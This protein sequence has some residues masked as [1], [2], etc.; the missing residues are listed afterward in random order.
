M[1][2]NKYLKY[3]GAGLLTMSLFSAC[4]D[5]YESE[6]VEQFDIDYLFSRSDSAGVQARKFLNEIYANNLYNG[7]NRVG[8]DYLD[9]ATDDATSISNEEPDVLKLYMGQFTAS[10]R[11]T[12]DMYWGEFYNGIRKTNILINHIDVV[13][14]NLK[15][16]TATGKVNP[17]NVSMKAEARFLRAHFYFELVKRYGG[18]PLLG[19]E[20]YDLNDN[21]EL[22]RNTFEEC[23]KYIVDE[24]DAIQDDLRG[25]PMPDAG[26]FAH[27][28]TKE[29]CMAMKSRVLL[30]AASPLFNESP[31]VPGNEL[32]GYANY[33]PSRWNLAA[34]AA[35]DFI[36]QFGPNGKGNIN[37]TADVRDVFLSFY[38]QATNPELIF[39]RQDGKNKNI[40]TNN[41]PLG[42]TGNALG[43]G[44]TTP[45]QNLVDA[46]PM[47]DGKMPGE[48]SKYV[49]NIN[50]PY[51]NRDPRL[52]KTILHNG[53]SWLGRTLD[54]TQ[55][56]L[57]NPSGA[58]SNQTG[59]YM[60][61]F[62]GKYDSNGRTDY[63]DQQIHFWTMFRYAEI[64]LNYAEALNE[65]EAAPSDEVY[66]AIIALRQRAG[67]E[68]GDDGL[69]GLD[70]N[71]TQD[72]MREVIQNERRIEL[73][74]E[75]HRYW[76]IRRWKIAEDVLNQPLRGMS[77]SSNSG[78]V[79]YNEVDVLLPK[80]EARR[81]LYP[82]PYSEVIK[83]RNMIQNPN[84]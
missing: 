74:F 47:L 75:E 28:P 51:A 58:S 36:D 63:D 2:R 45:S 80:F 18:V 76:D 68:A 10:N 48:S 59:Y 11:V 26:E 73:A 21:M 61:K 43:N 82:I 84:W 3:L 15:Y 31:L 27:T 57:N 23:I 71:M 19:D 41:G 12:S 67:I 5:G 56:G 13:P 77:I 32:V 53:S 79:T 22:P 39:F 35:K 72:Q 52:N 24:L 55:G 44:R 1:I 8:G 60:C 16:T 30:Y 38:D 54:M 50:D 81:Y 78:R 62:M 29:A 9:A 20:V 66:N 17:L 7:H 69:Y 37:L 65:S 25:L 4:I 34:Q 70:S 64:L 46:F 49:Y 40:E 33:D 42:F 6:P 14:F 83:N